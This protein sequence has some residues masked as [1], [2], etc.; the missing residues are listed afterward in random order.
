VLCKSGLIVVVVV[1]VVV[2][3][4]SRYFRMVQ[5]VLYFGGWVVA[6]TQSDPWDVHL[7]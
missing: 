6:K 2:D 7:R 5:V 4:A 3:M 1:V